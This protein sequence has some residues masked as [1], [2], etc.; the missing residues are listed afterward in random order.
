ALETRLPQ[1]RAV[2][3]AVAA[4]LDYRAHLMAIAI[5][6]V[7]LLAGLALRQFLNVLNIALVFL[8]AVLAV[9][10]RYGLM[11]SL[12]ACALSVL[13]YNFFFLPPLYTLTVA[14]PEN[15]LAL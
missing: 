14:E 2:G 10:A 8:T 12:F 9:A 1:L 5:V 11:P 4:S 3:R 6:A 13:A 7:A 15:V